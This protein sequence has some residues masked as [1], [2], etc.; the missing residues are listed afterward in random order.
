MALRLFVWLLLV[1]LAGCGTSPLVPVEERQTSVEQPK[2]D[3]EIDPGVGSKA[4]QIKHP[5]AE[6]H[7]NKPVNKS[8]EKVDV[9]EAKGKSELWRWP[10]NGRVVKEFDEQSGQKGIDIATTLNTSVIASRAGK[11][12]Y[13]GSGLKGYGK[14]IIIKHDVDY[15]SAYAKNKKVLVKEGQVVNIGER[16]AE[17]GLA[18]Q[19]NSV[20]HFQIRYKGKAI[21]P[22]PLLMSH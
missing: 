4:P 7:A 22:I 13:V 2:G 21:N 18:P 15:V 20:L 14:L 6:R 17:L 10:V 19:Q 9:V 12:I 1:L 8:S 11:A 5:S 3:F 16:V